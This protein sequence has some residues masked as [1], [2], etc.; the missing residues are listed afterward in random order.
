FIRIIF[1]GYFFCRMSLS[2]DNTQIAFQYR[3]NKD[4]KLAHFVFNSMSSP[5]L[6][7]IGMKL[8]SWTIRWNLPFQ[9]IIKSTVFKQFCGGE[10]LHE[11]AQ[12][13]SVLAKYDVGVA[14]DYG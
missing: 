3:T 7:K 14:L 12:T 9:G 5:L 11:A 13:A 1:A 4:L 6:T 8:A 10:D 2:F